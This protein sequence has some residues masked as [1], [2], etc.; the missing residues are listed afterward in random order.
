VTIDASGSVTLTG[1]TSVSVVSL[2]NSGALTDAVGSTIT[3]TGTG[4]G[5]WTNTSNNYT[6][7]GTIIFDG[8]APQI[9]ASNFSSLTIDGASTAAVLEGNVTIS[10][11]LTITSVSLTTGTFNLSVSGSGGDVTSI[12]SGGT[13][14]L[15]S[16]VYS[17]YN[18]TISPGGTYDNTGNGNV[19]LT[20]SLSDSN[21]NFTAGT[22]TYFLTGNGSGQTITTTGGTSIQLATVSVGGT[23]TNSGLGTLT[24]TNSMPSQAGCLSIT[25]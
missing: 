20:G 8:A 21:G 24:V 22:G 15:G 12:G 7:N 9:G 2:A 14:N 17:F 3:V 13:L 1:A 18:V 4:A 25:T 5:T 16:G 11:N 23:Y 10:S 19:T 6:A